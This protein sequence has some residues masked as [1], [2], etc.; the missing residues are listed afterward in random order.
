MQLKGALKVVNNGLKAAEQRD[1]DQFVDAMGPVMTAADRAIEA[2]DEKWAAME[3]IAARTRTYLGED[4]KAA[5]EDV[6]KAFNGFLSLLG[7]TTRKV[8]ARW[9]A[10]CG[11]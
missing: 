7:T 2:A 10:V 4:A 5:V 8:C 1:D 3:E 11:C 9:S 6:F